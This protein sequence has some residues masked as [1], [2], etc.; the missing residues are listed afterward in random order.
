[1]NIFK[2]IIL[3][4]T[5]ALLLSG[6]DFGGNK[7]FTVG[8]FDGSTLLE[9]VKV[10]K[11]ETVNKPD[12]DIK[13]DYYV[14]DWYLDSGLN[15]I[16]DFSEPVTSNL[17]LYGSFND[18]KTFEYFD[19]DFLAANSPF[20][21]DT[22]FY[23]GDK[24][25]TFNLIADDVELDTYLNIDTIKLMGCLS[26]LT[27]ENVTKKDRT[28]SIKTN[29][30]LTTG[31]GH[32]ILSRGVSKERVYFS[33]PIKVLER[34]VELVED[35]IV[36]YISEHSV[37]FT[38]RLVNE[39]ILNPNE[40]GHDELLADLQANL[41]RYF[42]MDA[43]SDFRLELQELS[44]DLSELTFMITSLNGWDMSILNDL[45]D[46]RNL[47]VHDCLLASGREYRLKIDLT[48]ARTH[49]VIQVSSAGNNFYKG[50]YSIHVSGARFSSLFISKSSELIASSNQMIS[51]NNATVNLT[52]I[53]FYGDQKITGTIEITTE[54]ALSNATILLAKYES[55]EPGDTVEILND[56]VSG[57]YIST[58]METTEV[59]LICDHSKNGTVYQDSG[60]SY[61][62]AKISM[63]DMIFRTQ[64]EEM[65]LLDMLVD[66]ATLL[67]KIGYGVYSGEYASALDHIG[68]ITGIDVLRNPAFR[69]LDYLGTI[70]DELKNIERK[71]DILDE[72]IESIK[73]QLEDLEELEIL[74]N[75]MTAYN[76]W[77]DFIGTYYTPMKDYINNYTNS[78][79]KY[80]YDLVLQSS[81]EE[82]SRPVIT[83]YFDVDGNVVF[84]NEY[85][86]FSVDGKTIDT[87]RTYSVSIP[88]LHHAIAGIKNNKNHAYVDI[89]LDIAADLLSYKV[90]NEKDLGDLLKT[91]R[92]YAMKSY[93][94]N[95]EAMNNFTNSF[96]N[97]CKAFTGQITESTLTNFTPLYS[98]TLMLEAINNFGFEIEPDLNIAAMK[99][100]ATFYSAKSIVDFVS[101]IDSGKIPSSLN[102]KLIEDVKNELTS[103]RFYHKN[104]L[105]GNVYC[106]A[107]KT[108]VKYS[109]DAYGVYGLVDKKIFRGDDHTQFGREYEAYDKSE[110]SSIT[111]EDIALMRVKLSL[112]NMIKGNELTFKQYLGYIGMIPEKKFELVRGIIIN[113]GNL[114]EYEDS[115]LNYIDSSMDYVSITQE[116]EITYTPDNSRAEDVDGLYNGVALSGVVE[117]FNSGK[118]YNGISAYAALYDWANYSAKN[119]LHGY[120]LDNIY[121]VRNGE[122]NPIDIG[123]ASYYFNLSPVEPRFE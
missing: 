120:V 16:Y 13:K 17:S 7:T 69:V 79:Y 95:S 115:N 86:T 37:K 100:E 43:R 85:K 65:S 114:M 26:D 10:N 53:E 6:C 73:K 76:T 51:I 93:F 8:F 27:V 112:S 110:F 4:S 109:C 89:E 121:Y 106:Y 77:N 123:A 107:S 46:N 56:L 12:E 33:T 98:F 111:K 58:N 40:L 97:L 36:V 45:R 32:I 81:L 74:N 82:A 11:G 104:D 9:E 14:Q 88:K 63:E 42:Y 21:T 101:V 118:T 34:R 84:P 68:R 61:E 48:Y 91:L 87:S 29:G 103:D 83:L 2:K 59:E 41:D 80:F 30:V 92:F 90:I 1:M 22:S 75:F 28:I 116:F 18:S 25:V 60:S 108:Y 15:S 102:D 19:E 23:E 57:Y 35:S 96:V 117:D 38:I 5:P 52:S 31:E 70:M 50:T 62:G 54:D 66:Q 105:D 47:R 67:G 20:K 49:S 122:N 113:L 94:N 119:W 72:K 24:N 64:E 44:E 78:Y 39:S 55:E 3:L 71:L 99:L